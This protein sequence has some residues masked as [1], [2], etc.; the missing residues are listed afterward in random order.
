MILATWPS[1]PRDLAGHGVLIGA[2][3]LA[4]F[5]ELKPGAEL[6]RTH[7]IHEHDGELASLR[8]PSMARAP[9]LRVPDRP[10]PRS[11]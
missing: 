2:H 4:H 3:D 10:V 7:E 8:F 6:G 11:R 5:L 9:P 1:K